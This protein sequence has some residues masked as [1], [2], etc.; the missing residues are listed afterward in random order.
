[1]LKKYEVVY[2]ETAVQDISDKLD[3]IL[4]VIGDVYV[5]EGWYGRLRACIQD[6]LTVFPYKYPLLDIYPWDGKGVR[7]VEFFNDVILYSV[8]DVIFKVYIHGIITK[9]QS[10]DKHLKEISILAKQ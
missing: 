4:N 3:Y 10:V 9:G 7:I 1:M 5:A 2:I 6:K 8:D